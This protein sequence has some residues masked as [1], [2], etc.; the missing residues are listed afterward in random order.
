MAPVTFEV[1]DHVARLRL[2]LAGARFDRAAL[3]SLTSAAIK[4]RGRTEDV[5]AVVVTSGENFGLGW[6][7]DA[8]AEDAIAGLPPLGAAFDAVAAI[9]QPIVA[10]ITGEALSAGLELALACDILVAATGAQLGMPEASLGTVPRGGGTQRL[11]RAVG[12]AAGLRMLLSG[13][14]IDAAEALRIGLV[15]EV[16]AGSAEDAAIAIATTIASR[17]P[18]ATRL[19]KEAVYRGADLPL[20][21]GLAVELDLTVILQTTADRAEGVQAFVGKRPPRFENR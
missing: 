17:G 4:A 20:A 10:A 7:A 5:Y 18:I 11:P 16:A 15:S 19:A 6:S 13:E 3:E 21:N 1:Q 8:L 14:S 9:P 2:D 12:R